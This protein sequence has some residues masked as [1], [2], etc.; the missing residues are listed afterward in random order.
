MCG[1]AGFALGDTAAPV[2][3]DLL[4]AMSATLRHRGPDD[5]GYYLGPAAGLV[6]R[7]LAVVDPAGGTQPVR[8][9][10]GT[11]RVVFNGEIYNHRRLRADLARRGHV[12]ASVCDSEVIP[13]LYEEYGPDFPAH[14]EGMFAVAL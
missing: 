7:R 12:M 11:V 4:L 14:L 5:D 6:I 9:E 8:N 2:G 3:R 1:I 13:H 10:D